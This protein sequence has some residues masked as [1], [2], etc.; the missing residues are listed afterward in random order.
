MGTLTKRQIKKNLPYAS[1]SARWVAF[2]SWKNYGPDPITLFQATWTVP[3]APAGSPPSSF[4]L[5]NGLQL[6]D[7]TEGFNP[8]NK[9]VQPVLQWDGAQGGWSV[10]LWSAGVP[11]AGGTQEKKRWLPPGRCLP[12]K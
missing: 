6:T 4:F 3:P 1:I 2:A 5:F 8:A 9:I 12:A 11:G 7:P 10:A